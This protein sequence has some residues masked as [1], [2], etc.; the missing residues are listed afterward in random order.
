MG[1]DLR[2]AGVGRLAAERARRPARPAEDLVDQRELHLAVAEAAEIGTEVARP[3]P[4]R[5]HLLLQRR[6]QLPVHRVRLVVHEL[7]TE[8]EVDRLDLGLHEL[9]DPVELLLELRFGREVPRHGCSCPEAAR[10]ASGR[11]AGSRVPRAGWIDGPRRGLA[12][13]FLEH[14]LGQRPAAHRSVR[15]GRRPS[16]MVAAMNT[17]SGICSS[18]CSSA[19]TSACQIVSTPPYPSAARREQ[20]VLARRVHRRTLGRRGAAVADEA[21]EDQHRHLLELVDVRL[22]RARHAGLARGVVGARAA[23]VAVTVALRAPRLARRRADQRLR[24]ARDGT[25]GEHHEAERLAVRPA[26]RPR[27][28]EEHRPQRLGRDRLVGVA[29]D[30]AGRREALEQ[31]DGVGRQRRFGEVGER[32]ATPR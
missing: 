20:Q 16:V 15:T 17:S 26:R 10:L 31:A 21:R 8:R 32:S 2:V 1:E 13:T 23:V 14:Q 12:P 25:V 11:R 9:A 27:R 30:R 22:H 19:S 3:Q 24:L 29:P 6:E 4:L 5:L 18:S 7:V 28:R